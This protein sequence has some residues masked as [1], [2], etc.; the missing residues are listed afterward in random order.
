MVAE[1]IKE[2]LKDLPKEKISAAVFEG[3]NIVLY[4]EDKD[5]CINGPDQ[6]KS[7][8]N[9]IKKRIELRPDP[10][11]CLPIKEAEEIIRKI[12]PEDASP[13]KIIFDPQRSMVVIESPNPGAAIGKQGALLKEIRN[14]SFWV[15]V[16]RRT[17]P[18]RSQLI[19]SIRG[20]LYENSDERRKFLNKVGETVYNGW[21]KG[22]TN[23]WVRLSM[24]GAGR[25]VGRSAVLLQT[26]QSRVLLDCGVDP[27]GFGSDAYPILEAPEFNIQELD[28]VII[29][30]AHLDHSGSLPLLFKYGYT[31]PV[32]CTEP[33]RD[34]MSLLQLDMI[35]IMKNQG[36]DPIYTA[37]E[38]KKCVMST[39]TLGFEEVTDVTPDVR[40]TFYNS[41]HILGSAMAHLHIGNG[42]H[43]FLYTADLKYGQ[44]RLLQPAA[45]KFPRLESMMVEATYGGKD[46]VHPPREESEA[47][48]AGYIKD[49][50]KRGGKILI[51]VLGVGRAQE[52]MLILYD[53]MKTGELEKI[54]V[55]IDGMVWDINAITTA[56]PEFLNKNIRSQMM[57]GDENPF[58]DEVFK[59]V[60]SRKERTELMEDGGPCI[61]L[62]TSGMLVGG[63]SQ[64]YFQFLA[65]DKRHTIIFVSYQGPGSLGRRVQQGEKDI[66]CSINGR[67]P[68]MLHVNM[69]VFSIDAFT[70]H[71]GRNEL[72]NFMRKCNPQPR[73]VIT[74]HGESSR[75]IDLASSIHKQFR[76]E[77]VCPKNLETVRL[78]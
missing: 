26:P 43:N 71:S 77:T 27:T 17:P 75:C 66:M 46:N 49:T 33:T 22:R 55:Y 32:Y 70:G 54:P 16:I 78:R 74:N 8:V 21:V 31:G 42:L 68:E 59:R 67:A 6:V 3:A 40:L 14:Q 45:T 36:I 37:E 44:T 11:I 69:D 24:L 10:S 72:M 13:D 56:Y 47:E 63:A 57:R 58:M 62:A 1:I 5:F 4:T 61:I 51:P 41:G 15:P 65:P 64:E 12:I 53:L 73:K 9:K 7:V 19:E 50:V 25:Q 34:V 30:H 76:V 48:L 18:I 28:A 52:L 20:V 60:G 38:V 23:E 35:K 2:I 39:I 29:T